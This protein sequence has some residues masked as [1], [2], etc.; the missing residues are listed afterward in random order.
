MLPVWISDRLCEVHAGAVALRNTKSFSDELRTKI[1]LTSFLWQ[2]P[3]QKVRRQNLRIRDVSY[4]S[5]LTSLLT[6][7]T[8]ERY[9]GLPGI[10][11]LFFQREM[12]N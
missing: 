10:T 12:L 4:R 2:M 7:D 1:G 3:G 9:R 5:G 11:K 8:G 6:Y